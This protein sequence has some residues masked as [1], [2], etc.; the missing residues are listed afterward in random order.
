MVADT[1]Y[2]D[3]L[4]VSPDA[5][6][7]EIKKAYRK[8]AIK[9][10][11][12]KNPNDDTAHQ[13][14]QEV[15]AHE[16]I[17]VFGRNTSSNQH[18]QIGEAY[19]VL[20]DPQLRAAY[21]KNGKE[22]AVPS[23]GFGM[24]AVI[25][26][27]SLMKDLM[28]T[29]EMSEKFEK[30][31]EEVDKQAA[32][33]IDAKKN[34]KSSNG[35]EH[36][37]SISNSSSAAQSRTP[38]QSAATRAATSGENPV[39]DAAGARASSGERKPSAFAQD[40]TTGAD[41]TT[42]QPLNDGRSSVFSNDPTT[43]STADSRST[44]TAATTATAD[45][46]AKQSAASTSDDV[47]QS[48]YSQQRPSGVPTRLAIMDD[49]EG[50]G[51]DHIAGVSAQEKELRAKEKKKGLSKEQQAE[52]QRYEEERKRVRKERVDQL[53]EKLVNRVSVW[54]EA[55]NKDHVTTAFRE[56]T[57][58]ERES[59]K[60]ESFGIEILHAIGDIYLMKGS[61]YL[62]QKHIFGSGGFFDRIRQKG[63]MVK[64]IWGTVSTAL[65]AQS[66]MEEMA[67]A[68]EKGGEAWTDEARADYERKVTG[69][70]L[71]AAWRGSKFEIQGVL[72]E[73]CDQVLLDPSVSKHKQRDRAEALCIIGS[74]MKE[75]HRTPEEENENMVFEQLM[76]DAAKKKEKEQQEKKKKH[77]H[78]PFRSKHNGSGASA[79]A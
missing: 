3:A 52:L 57:K 10:H 27:I 69:K 17:Q 65:D 26:E 34:G 39:D 30:E 18:S 48:P 70:I 33:E 28:G 22:S 13:K 59:M 43:A 21:D 56:K 64:D 12:D 37:Q 32:T 31:Q 61:N 14:F 7:V 8:L 50:H 49:P 1:Q 6:E 2:Y 73:V 9:L 79:A 58:L 67:R 51:R 38:S 5:N 4:G 60:M 40:P 63:G 68:E 47:T 46:G 55:S 75:A 36:R 72:R 44:S 77:Q 74:I 16:L 29:M 15:F 45:T 71:A 62:R 35:I 42:P 76:A 11:P 78:F 25:G 41:S 24:T 66:T 53:A 20:S 23:S 54:T 19:Q